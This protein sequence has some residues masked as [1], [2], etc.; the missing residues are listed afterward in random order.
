[1]ICEEIITALDCLTRRSTESYEEYI[2]RA[3]QS[4][5]ATT[6]K[7]ADLQDNMDIKRLEHFTERDAERLERYH[8]AWLHLRASITLKTNSPTTPAASSPL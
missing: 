4:P 1:M 2:E 3:N 5:L 6:V 7:I 8:R